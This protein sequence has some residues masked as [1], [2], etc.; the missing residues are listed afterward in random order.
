MPPNLQNTLYFRLQDQE[1]AKALQ[2]REGE[3]QNAD[4]ILKAGDQAERQRQGAFERQLT[5]AELLGKQ[6]ALDGKE[7]PQFS[8]EN[9][10][11]GAGGAASETRGQLRA[12]EQK[13]QLL[14]DIQAL[15]DKEAARREEM[16]QN[17][18]TD[19]AGIAG[20]SAIDVAR[21]NQGG[22]SYRAEHFPH[23]AS[24]PKP[25]SPMDPKWNPYAAKMLNLR[26]QLS[27][28][29]KVWNQAQMDAASTQLR[30][31]EQDAI[32]YARAAGM[33]VPDYQS[34]EDL[35]TPAVPAL[36]PLQHDTEAPPSDDDFDQYLK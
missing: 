18:Q 7:T 32:G 13:G 5:Q 33:N 15:K 8:N 30:R 6:A 2:Q 29:A 21:I 9:F 11:V 4:I 10:N 24:A 26:A 1:R 19:R 34:S 16:Q 36:E 20:Q 25:P 3:A 14:R 22:L 23:A 35:P 17:A 12:T 31:A 27:A 28:N